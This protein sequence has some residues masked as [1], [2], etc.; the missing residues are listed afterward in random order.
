MNSKKWLTSGTSSRIVSS[1]FHAGSTRR[2]V[3]INAP[4]MPWNETVQVMELLDQAREQ[5]G[6]RYANDLREAGT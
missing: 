1:A 3:W 6:L 2:N 5:L 4:L